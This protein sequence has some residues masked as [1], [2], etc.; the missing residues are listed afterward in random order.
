MGGW[1]WGVVCV[2]VRARVQCVVCD[3]WV[4][5]RVLYPGYRKA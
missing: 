5:G 3:V 2:C 1:R 4:G